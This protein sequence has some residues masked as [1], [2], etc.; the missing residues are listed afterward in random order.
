ML[1]NANLTRQ[2]RQTIGRLI[3]LQGT[4]LLL[5]DVNPSYVILT[6]YV[7]RT[8]ETQGSSGSLCGR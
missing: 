1:L 2:D 3:G 8:W 4:V 7:V 6:S 5:C